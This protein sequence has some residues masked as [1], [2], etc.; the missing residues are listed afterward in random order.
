[1]TNDECAVGLGEHRSNASGHRDYR[2]TIHSPGHTEVARL[3][4]TYRSDLNAAGMFIDRAMISRARLFLTRIGVDGWGQLSLAEQCAIPKGDRRVVGWLIVTNRLCPTPDY[5]VLGRH[6]L[7]GLAARYHRGFHDR[8]RTTAAEL[9]YAPHVTRLHW[10]ALVKAAALAEMAPER[11]TEEAINDSQAALEV[12]VLRHRPYSQASAQLATAFFG[13]RMTLFHAGVLLT[14]PR[15]LFPNQQADRDKAW[16]SAPA[17]LTSTLRGYAQTRSTR[18]AHVEAVLREFVSWLT[19][20]AAE[21]DRVAGLRQTHIDDY[22]QH[23][24][25]R[26]S[27]RGGGPLSRSTVTEHLR[28]LRTC[29]RHLTESDDDHPAREFMFPDDLIT[30]K[31]AAPRIL[32]RPTLAKLLQAA[33]DDVDPFVRLCVEFL[34]CTGLRKNEFIDL[35]L[36]SVVQIGPTYWLQVPRRTPHAVRYLPLHPELKELLDAW[37]AIHPTSPRAPHLLV[38]YGRRINPGRVER[39]VAKAAQT[40]GI[41]NITPR[42]LRHTS[43]QQPANQ[44]LSLEAITA[45]F[46]HQCIQLKALYS[47]PATSEYCTIRTRGSRSTKTQPNSDAAGQVDP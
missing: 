25:S 40:A 33:R 20:N 5:L 28:T 23:L 24:A 42:Q 43:T 30:R 19:I 29:F 32:D 41:G 22:T 14:P 9:G 15:K 31:G 17:R 34:L 35:T 37:T 6:H 11:I 3:I 2:P 47:P 39:A 26:L 36:S 27:A 16:A 45:I 12:A 18:Q 38:E 7:G 46:G 44:G 8:F 4:A 1:M 10:S 13:V 21:V